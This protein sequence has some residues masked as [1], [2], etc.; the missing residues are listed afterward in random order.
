[1]GE[2]HRAHDQAPETENNEVRASSY[3]VNA[4]MSLFEGA[5]QS[6]GQH[7]Y[8]FSSDGGKEKGS[9][10]T[11]RALVTIEQYKA[12]ING[13]MGLGVVPINENNKCKFSVVDIDIYKQEHV[14]LFVDAVER[15]SFP[16]VPFRTKSGGLHLYLFYQDPIPAHTAVEITR[17]L[18]TALA[19]DTFVKRETN[20]M[21]EVF[22]KQTKL[23]SGAVGNWINLP[24]YNASD[25]KQYAFVRGK[26]AKI[27]DALTYISDRM[28]TVDSLREF[29]SELP[30]RDGPPCIQSLHLLNPFENES[31]RNEFLFSFGIYLKKKDEQF[32]EQQLYDVNESLRSPLDKSE[33]ENTI[34]ASLRKRD[35]VYKCAQPPLCDYCNRQVC[36]N[37]TFGVGKQDGYFSTLEYGKMRQIKTHSPYYEWQVRKQGDNDWKKIRFKSEDDVIGQQT[38]LALCMRELHVLPPKLKQT[39]WFKIVNQSLAELE[40]EQVEDEFNLS[41]ESLFY[42]HLFDFLFNR[43][44]AANAEEVELGRVFYSENRQAYCFRARDLLEFLIE[45]KN[46]KYFTLNEIHALLKDMGGRQLKLWKKGRHSQVRCMALDEA[47]LKSM[48]QAEKDREEAVEQF[49]PDFSAWSE[50]DF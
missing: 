25:T 11:V 9:N 19:I 27:E 23:A 39:E 45:R 31:N 46:F 18:A 48:K 33:L 38:F 50:E 15:N 35:Y 42:N 43:A 4:F 40:I 37:R 36:Q 47:S 1:M 2:Q 21:Y 10:K 6:Y 13:E 7:T 8:K 16:F 24:Y 29:I 30:Y 14:K 22:P 32:W 41:Y 5:K 17:Q 49:E 3:I 34:I 20:Q 26:P 28:Q 12:H 44:M